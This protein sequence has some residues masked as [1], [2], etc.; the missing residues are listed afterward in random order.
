[1]KEPLSGNARTT[2]VICCSLDGSI[3]SDTLRTLQFGQ[4]AMQITQ[5]VQVNE[6]SVVE[7][8]IVCA[9]TPARLPAA[10]FI[11]DGERKRLSNLLREKWQYT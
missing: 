4:R 6:L 7:W 1:M 2:F 9:K 5:H 10:N 8:N 3:Q 11:M